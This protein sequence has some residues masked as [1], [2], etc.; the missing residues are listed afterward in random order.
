M[1]R[2]L[3][4]RV[5]FRNQ[6]LTLWRPMKMGAEPTQTGGKPVRRIRLRNQTSR[7]RYQRVEVKPTKER[8]GR[9]S[10]GGKLVR[11][12]RIRAWTLGLRWEVNLVEGTMGAAK[13]VVGKPT[14]CGLGYFSCFLLSFS[15]MMEMALLF[16]ATYQKFLIQTRVLNRVL[17][18]M[19]PHRMGGLF[20]LLQPNCSVG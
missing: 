14:V 8:P 18:W 1:G 11:A 6:S 13:R 4:H 17:P 9:T 16:L 15:Q 10:E 19:V 12:I 3:T 20:H 7:G 2:S 5:R